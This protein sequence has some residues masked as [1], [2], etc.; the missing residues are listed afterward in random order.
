M[1]RGSRHCYSPLRYTP[2]QMPLVYQCQWQ[3]H[4]MKR[5]ICSLLQSCRV[6]GLS[7][8]TFKCV[9]PWKIATKVRLYSNYRLCPTSCALQLSLTYILYSL[10]NN[11]FLCYS[12]LFRLSEVFQE[13][14]QYLQATI[15][16]VV[17][18]VCFLCVSHRNNYTNTH[19]HTQY[20]SVG[21]AH[22]RQNVVGSNPTYR[23]AP[24]FLAKKAVQAV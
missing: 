10:Q 7:S 12:S 9:A 6:F 21:R 24:F 23:A 5:L 13:G 19:T 14:L 4:A 22:C 17:W 8:N 1:C 15:G 20:S 16:I 18:W 3:I 11:M 2:S